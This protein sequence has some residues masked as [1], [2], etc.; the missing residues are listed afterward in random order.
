M[1]AKPKDH[2]EAK[3]KGL[4]CGRCQFFRIGFKGQ[5]CSVERN[6]DVDDIACYEYSP[7]LQDPYSNIANDRY[8]IQLRRT[9]LGE[10]FSFDEPKLVEEL[11]SHIFNSGY[12]NQKMGTHAD[13]GT[14][15]NA[16]RSIA[17]SRN[18]VSH[19]YTMLL[20]L[21]Y[22]L[23]EINKHANMWI[24]SKYE[25]I[26]NLK[27]EAARKNAFMRILPE[28]IDIANKLEKLVDISKYVDDKLTTNEFT[29]KAILNSSERLWSVTKK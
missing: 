1:S 24:F 27:N 14:L 23:E 22:D 8:V 25:E 20:D 10:R 19:I 26:R 3:N 13:L 5:N 21:K 4:K 16:L 18:R 29:V 12:V 17:V 6:V 9:L 11:K 15:D 7:V 2:P 28:S